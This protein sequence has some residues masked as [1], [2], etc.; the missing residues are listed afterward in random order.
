MQLPRG[1]RLSAALA[2]PRMPGRYPGQQALNPLAGFWPGSQE[3]GPSPRAW[4]LAEGGRRVA[5]AGGGVG[6][7]WMG[8]VVTLALQ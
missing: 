6:K 2:P 1:A 7:S 5:G 3:K 8:A 4:V